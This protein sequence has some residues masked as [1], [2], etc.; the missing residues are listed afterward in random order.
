MRNWSISITTTRDVGTINVLF[1]PWFVTQSMPWKNISRSINTQCWGYMWW[2]S[3]SF[4]CQDNSITFTIDGDHIVCKVVLV[5]CKITM[6]HNDTLTFAIKYL[7]MFTKAWCLTQNID[8]YM[9][10]MILYSPQSRWWMTPYFKCLLNSSK[11]PCN[12]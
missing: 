3:R 6:Q 12:L 8:I 10:S 1:A 9:S 5:D 11:Y 2:L 4:V 7:N